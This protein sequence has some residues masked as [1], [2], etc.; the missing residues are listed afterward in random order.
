MEEKVMSASDLLHLVQNT[1]DGGILIPSV[2]LRGVLIYG[3]RVVV[4]A[5][6]GTV[7]MQLGATSGEAAPAAIVQTRRGRSRKSS[8]TE[9]AASDPNCSVLAYNKDA[10]EGAIRT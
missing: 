7:T 1:T 2:H 4:M 9:D 8:N 3:D 6:K 10:A 5:S